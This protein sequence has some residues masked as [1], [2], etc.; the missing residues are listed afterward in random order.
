MGIIDRFFAKTPRRVELAEYEAFFS[1]LA[2][3]ALC[4]KKLASEEVEELHGLCHR[5]PIFVG[6]PTAELNAMVDRVVDRLNHDFDGSLTIAIR[7]LNEEMRQS[8]F[9]H[10]LEIIAADRVI[11]EDEEKFVDELATKL[12]IDSEFIDK[13]AEI[14]GIK[15]KV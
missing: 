11:N 2:A 10:A 12:N 4:D 1:I 6:L 5:L 15:N 8:A 3:T 9:I 13:A 7:S 14:I